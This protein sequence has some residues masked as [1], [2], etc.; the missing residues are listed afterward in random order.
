[1]GDDEMKN[2]EMKDSEIKGSERKGR[3]TGE[4]VK[5]LLIWGAGDQGIVTLDCALAMNRYSRIDF[6]ELKEKGHRAIPEYLI[7]REDDGLDQVL[8][9]YDEVIVATGSNE[10]RE[11]KIS[12]LVSLGVPLA[13]IIHPTAVISPLSRIAKGCTI[14]P[15]A[16]INAYA[17]IGTGCII[18]TQADIEHDCV[19]EDFVNVCPKVSMAGHTVVGRKTFLGI[20]CTIIDG[21]R[22]GTEATVGAG[23][24]VIRDVPDH[25]AVAGVPAKDIRS[26]R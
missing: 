26:Y 10:L 13:V 7:R 25:A 11:K 20:G 14:H 3:N 17:S 16:V 1:M 18:N 2:D 22:I 4:P 21:I 12:M 24:V 15:Y 5:R 6:M 23:A 19:V 8:K 9:S